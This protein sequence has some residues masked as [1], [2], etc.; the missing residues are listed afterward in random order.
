[1]LVKLDKNGEIK[2]KIAF[3]NSGRGEDTVYGIHLKG[4]KVY[5]VG[6]SNYFDGLQSKYLCQQ[7]T[8]GSD[9]DTVY[10]V[11]TLIRKR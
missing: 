4:D 6:Y 1:M 9:G 7:I 2:Y 5:V 3:S 8:E 10:S 11:N